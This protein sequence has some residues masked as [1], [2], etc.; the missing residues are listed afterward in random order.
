M[1]SA[2]RR[3]RSPA[4]PKP[5]ANPDVLPSRS[6]WPAGQDEG[7]KRNV[8]IAQ[9]QREQR[10]GNDSGGRAEP[11]D[12]RGDHHEQSPGRGA[13]GGGRNKPF[14]GTVPNLSK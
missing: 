6:L 10:K 3:W 11:F 1:K 5:Q 4:D 13:G 2:V 8:D 7:E 9:S 14:L 12:G